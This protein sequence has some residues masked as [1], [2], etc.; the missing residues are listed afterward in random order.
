MSDALGLIA[1][2]VETYHFKENHYKSAAYHI[3]GIVVR[4]SNPYN[5]F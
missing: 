5:S 3:K 4:K 2:G 1:H